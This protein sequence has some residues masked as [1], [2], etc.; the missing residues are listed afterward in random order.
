MRRESLKRTFF[1]GSTSFRKL[2]SLIFLSIC[3]TNKGVVLLQGLTFVNFFGICKRKIGGSE[4]PC[5]HRAN[6][7]FHTRRNVHSLVYSSPNYL[8]HC[9]LRTRKHTRC[10]RHKKGH[11]AKP[12]LLHDETIPFARQKV[13]FCKAKPYVLHPQQHKD[14]GQASSPA[15]KECSKKLTNKPL[16][17]ASALSFICKSSNGTK[18]NV[19]PRLRIKTEMH[20]LIAPNI[21]PTMCTGANKTRHGQPR[22]TGAKGRTGLPPRDYSK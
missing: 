11:D 10:A 19:H 1:N 12:Y 21:W 5:G 4:T 7:A 16:Q 15:P 18:T 20:V 2:I 22:A 14:N 8:P 17:P 9:A 13:T 6:H 3:K